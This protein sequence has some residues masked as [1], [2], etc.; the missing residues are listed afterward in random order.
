[1]EN[2]A[3]FYYEQLKEAITPGKTLAEYYCKLYGI[4]HTKS[5]TIIINRLVG[6]FGRFTVFFAISSMV[7]TYPTRQ[8]NIYPLLYAI[9]NN[10]F[11]EAHG[12]STMQSRENL[13]KVIKDMQEQIAEQRKARKFT[14]RSS[15]GLGSSG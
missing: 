11:E 5:E 8:E 15:E 4:E 13:N 6:I 14:P 2:K 3:E 10:K 9:C 12:E 1:M 7:G